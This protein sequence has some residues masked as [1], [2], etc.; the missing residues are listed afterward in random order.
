VNTETRAENE[1]KFILFTYECYFSRLQAKKMF[2]VERDML[3]HHFKDKIVQLFS[4][5]PLSMLEP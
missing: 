2:K 4:K 3:L 5:L 1:Y